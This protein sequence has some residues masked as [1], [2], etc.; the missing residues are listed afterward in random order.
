MPRGGSGR[1]GNHLLQLI[2]WCGQRAGATHTGTRHPGRSHHQQREQFQAERTE[3]EAHT[4]AATWER[5]TGAGYAGS[6]AGMTSTKSAGST[7]RR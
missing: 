7:E 3:R 6:A 4:L 5:Y 1:S 2:E